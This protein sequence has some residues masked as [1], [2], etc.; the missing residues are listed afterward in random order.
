ML[1]RSLL[2]AVAAGTLMV[3]AYIGE[4]DALPI[5]APDYVTQPFM[6][7]RP[8][9][10]LAYGKDLRF[11][12]SFFSRIDDKVSVPFNELTGRAMV[13]LATAGQLLHATAPPRNMFM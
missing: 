4:A 9:P 3:A 11:E 12:P 5:K 8:P 2:L 6:E 7:Y 10:T 1:K 13:T